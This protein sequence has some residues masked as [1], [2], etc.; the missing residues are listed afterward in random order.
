MRFTS[1]SVSNPIDESF[2]L[3]LYSS[4]Q[5]YI[6]ANH[7]NGTHNGRFEYFREGNLLK[8]YK[9][10]VYQGQ[11]DIGS[12]VPYFVAIGGDRGTT[13]DLNNLIHYIKDIVIGTYEEHNVISCP[14]QTWSISWI[15][16]EYH[17]ALSGRN[18]W[19]TG[20]YHP[21]GEN[22]YRVPAGTWMYALFIGVWQRG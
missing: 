14:P 2:G 1:Y 12:T 11:T 16:A 5:G 15:L 22:L 3:N 4:E 21:T 19:Q 7:I 6:G 20:Q 9:N 17:S 10:G 18:W 13:Y 8:L